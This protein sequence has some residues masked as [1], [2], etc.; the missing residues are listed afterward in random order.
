MKRFQTYLKEETAIDENARALELVAEIDN[1]I[2]SIPTEIALDDRPAYNSGKKLGISMMMDDAM[3]TKYASMA[4]AIIEERDDLEPAP[5]KPARITKDFAFRHKDLEKYVYVNCRPSGKRSAAGDDPHELMTA[6]LMLKSSLPIPTTSDEMDVL[7][8]EVK[9]NLGNISGYKSGQVEKLGGDYANM[10]KAVSA[11]KALHDNGWGGA[12]KVYLTGQAWDDDVK[13]FQIT[14][15]GMQDFNS[16]DFIIK[17][18][19]KYMGVSLKKKIRLSEADPTLIN[20]SFSTLFQGKEFE[21][22]MET[23]DKSAGMFYL[24]VIARAKK[25]GVLDPATE[26]LMKKT[27][28]STKNWKLFI[29]QIPNEIINAE[30]KKSRSLFGKMGKIISQNKELIANQLVQLIFKADLKE[31]QSVDFDFSLVT[32]IGDYGARKGVVVEKAEYKNI[33][34]VS[35][36]IENLAS[37]GGASIDYTP[38]EVQAFQPGATAAMLKLDLSLGGTVLANIV[39][40]YKGNFRSAPSFT[41]FMSDE[42]KA[43]YRDLPKSS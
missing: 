4:N 30:L 27:R 14:K 25:D 9:K 22:L 18:G 19:S 6:G 7:I 36:K 24:R 1:A 34:T 32:G 43:I 29:Q 28:P 35:E 12:D 31:L 17:K 26:K 41:A 42:F 21:S 40:R 5:V 2:G 11:A 33:D 3:R 8:D 39:L 20:K 23:L 15:Y 38:G 37:K 13:K 16:S 10:A